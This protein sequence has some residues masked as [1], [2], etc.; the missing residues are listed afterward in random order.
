V[1]GSAEQSFIGELTLRSRKTEMQQLRPSDR[2]HTSPRALMSPGDLHVSHR[3]NFFTLTL[4]MPMSDLAASSA[5]FC[6]MSTG[7]EAEAREKFK[8][9]AQHG[10][11]LGSFDVNPARQ[12]TQDTALYC[13]ARSAGSFVRATHV[14]ASA[15]DIDVVEASSSPAAAAAT[16][17]TSSEVI[18]Y[19][20]LIW[21]LVQ[22][23]Q[24]RR[25]RSLLALVPNSSEHARL[26]NL[27]SLP[28][29]SV[30]ERKDYDRSQEYDWLTQNAKNY[31]GNWVAVSGDSLVAIA[32]TLRQLRRE[33]KNLSLARPPIIH[34]VE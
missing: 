24:L 34:F 3:R 11:N 26:R 32:D 4:P 21:S 6:T 2:Y 9:S 16:A 33:V 19:L 31:H 14:G 18:P 23:Q 22:A 5:G 25:A 29:T 10:E 17:P 8:T 20:S 12:L 28:V 7:P 13:R 27:L 30:S 1:I 15:L